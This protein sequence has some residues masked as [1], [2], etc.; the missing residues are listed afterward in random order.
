MANP[1]STQVGRSGR[2]GGCRSSG[3]APAVVP[4]YGRPIAKIG[5]AIAAVRCSGK[6]ARGFVRF[7]YQAPL[8]GRGVVFRRA[9]HRQPLYPSINW[10]VVRDV[11]RNE[12]QPGLD[13]GDAGVQRWA[14]SPAAPSRR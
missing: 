12:S 3:I 13:L 2:G 7:T 5:V 1:R 11:R 14:R 9:A 6:R 8:T 4:A 10:P